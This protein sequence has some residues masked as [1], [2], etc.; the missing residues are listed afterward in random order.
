MQG[1]GAKLSCVLPCWWSWP[2]FLVDLVPLLKELSGIRAS[3]VLIDLG[4]PCDRLSATGCYLQ[5]TTMP[6][7]SFSHMRVVWPP[8]NFAVAGKRTSEMTMRDSAPR[9]HIYVHIAGSN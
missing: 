7:N 5:V 1:T 6:R 8:P 4:V 9:R 2:G 3:G